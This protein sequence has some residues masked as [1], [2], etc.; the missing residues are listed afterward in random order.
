MARPVSTHTTA[1]FR[2][3]K[4]V[5]ADVEEMHWILRKD[6]SQI[7]EEALIEYLAKKAPKSAK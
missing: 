6:E 1:K 2:L 5:I 3:S 4:T 7:V